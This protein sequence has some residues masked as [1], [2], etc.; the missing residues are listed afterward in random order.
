MIACLQHGRLNEAELGLRT[1]TNKAFIF[2]FFFFLMWVIFKVF[3]E[4][5]I[6]LLLFCFGDFCLP[7]RHVGS[8]L[9]NQESNPY[10]V[11]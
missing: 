5:V 10:P 2:S 7:L 3:I 1:H 11:H 9:P 8:H 4:F 6:I